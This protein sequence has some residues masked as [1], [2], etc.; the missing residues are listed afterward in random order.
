MSVLS[1]R[2]SRVAPSATIAATQRAREMRAA[3]RDV[4]SL[5]AGEPD[6]DTPAHVADAAVDAIRR[7]ET[8]YTAIDGIPELKAA[9]AAKFARDNGLDYAEAEITVGTG[10]KQVLFNAL[11][12][13]LD[14]GDEVLIAA[15]YWVS[16]P[17][18]VRLNG[19]TPVILGTRA[20]DGFRLRPEAL[21]EA[22]TPRTK[23][24]ILNS[25]S[26]PTGA[27]YAE[28]ALRALTDVLL[29]HPHVWVLADD[30]YEHLVFDGFRF[31]T[32]AQVEPRLKERTLTLNGVSKSHAMTGWRIGYG[33]GPAALIAAMRKVQGQCTSNPCSIAQWAAVAALDGPQDGLA[34]RAAV[35]ARRRDMV[36]D[37]LNACP[38]ID[39]PRPEGAFYVFPSIAGLIGRTSAGGAPLADDAA[40]AAALLEEEAVAVVHGGAFGHSPAFR[41]SYATS[42]E[43]LAE[44]AAR[45]RRF[46]EGVRPA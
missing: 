44:A 31:A 15:P 45:I 2:L 37:A 9:I 5:S 35:Y 40:F 4:I 33:A 43:A 1:E 10:G 16:Y 18:M 19:G 26:N 30:I 38:G 34:E 8:K 12:A 27:A 41:V 23:W 29:E 21:A 42:D 39:C 3:G 25:P 36:V 28:D 7:G 20:E 6:F 13:T 46:C 11:A 32:P 24:L 17:D 22:I 14:P